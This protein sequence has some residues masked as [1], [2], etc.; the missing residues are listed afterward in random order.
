MAEQIELTGNLEARMVD[1]VKRY[2]ISARRTNYDSPWGF[3]VV[4]VGVPAVLNYLPGE[5]I[6]EEQEDH[7]EYE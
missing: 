3:D 2:Y 7:I 5:P 1:G 4:Y 6:D